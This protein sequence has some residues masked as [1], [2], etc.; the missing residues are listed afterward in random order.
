[1][2]YRHNLTGPEV[3][4]GARWAWKAVTIKLANQTLCRRMGL[5]RPCDLDIGSSDSCRV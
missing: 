2:C 5:E 1:M 4:H 3:G